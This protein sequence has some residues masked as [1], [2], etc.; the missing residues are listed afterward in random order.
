MPSYVV[1]STHL[2]EIV[3]RQ[4]IEAD[5]EEQARELFEVAFEEGEIEDDDQ[6]CAENAEPR[7]EVELA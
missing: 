3:Y 7:I 5:S 4:T 2:H 1:T 6:G